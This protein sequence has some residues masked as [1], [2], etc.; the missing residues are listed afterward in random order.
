MSYIEDYSFRTVIIVTNSILTTC[1][2]ASRA[3][4]DD[5][6]GSVRTPTLTNSIYIFLI[7]FV[8]VC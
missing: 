3:A 6:F 8:S 4:T 5:Y 2:V 1:F 7:N